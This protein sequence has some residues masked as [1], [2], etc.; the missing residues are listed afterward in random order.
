MKK[1]RDIVTVPFHL[2]LI[3]GA[4]AGT[5]A[6]LNVNPTALGGRVAEVADGWAEFRLTKLRFRVRQGGN[7][8]QAIAYEPGVADTVPATQ[9]NVMEGLYSSYVGAGETV[10]GSWVQVPAADCAGAATWYKTIIGATTNWEE[11]PGQIF[12]NSSTTAYYLELEFVMQFKGAIT[13][14]ATPE[15]RL[16]RAL[17]RQKRQLLSLLSLPDTDNVPLSKGLSEKSLGGSLQPTQK[18]ANRAPAGTQGCQERGR[19]GDP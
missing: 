3:N 4:T 1:S 12:I 17:A 19:G 2:M 16:Q 7:L 14:G 11:M 9:Q 6:T 13:D 10:P 18:Q 5:T 15:L 8:S